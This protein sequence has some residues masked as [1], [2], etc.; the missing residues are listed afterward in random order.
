MKKVICI[1]MVMLVTISSI[2]INASAT[3]ED[4][5][6]IYMENYGVCIDE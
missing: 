6:M 3:A 4:D 2:S 5:G 1:I